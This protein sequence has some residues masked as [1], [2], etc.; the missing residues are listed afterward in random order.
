MA[1]KPKN[2]DLPGVSGPGVATVRIKEIDKLCAIYVEARD[3]RIE[4][5][6][7]EVPAKKN[8]IAA[9]HAHEKELGR[10]PEGTIRYEYDGVLVLLT[11]GE[12][13]L[14]VKAASDESEDD[15][16]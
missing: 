3:E 11:H 12:E 4:C 6:Q 10:D 1:R 13:K 2:P 5:T 8:L 16:D 7:R 9:L 15:E 14:K